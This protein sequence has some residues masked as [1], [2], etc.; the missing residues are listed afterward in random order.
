M[1]LAATANSLFIRKLDPLGLRGNQIGVCDKANSTNSTCI[2]T[3]PTLPLFQQKPQIRTCTRALDMTIMQISNDFFDVKCLTEI[4]SR[5]E[6]G[7]TKIQKYHKK[8]NSEFLPRTGWA[9]FTH[10]FNIAGSPAFATPA[11]RSSNGPPVGIQNVGARCSDACGPSY[12]Q[13]FEGRAGCAAAGADPSRQIDKFEQEGLESPTQSQ[14]ERK[15][16]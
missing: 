6:V 9:S 8:G 1:F 2:V 4:N 13:E 16:K 10:S 7:F 14:T 11:G 5:R 12:G 15:R 3:Y